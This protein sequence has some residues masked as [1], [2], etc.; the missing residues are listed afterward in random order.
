MTMSIEPNRINS[1]QTSNAE[2]DQ[3]RASYKK[4][5]KSTL[6]SMLG[7][8]GFWLLIAFIVVYTLFPFYWAIVSS[9]TP[10]NDL[11]VTPVRFWP[12]AIT[13]EHYETVFSDGGFMRALLN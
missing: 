12:Q 2:L 7:K 4:A 10:T 8:I 3:I 6:P 9:L 5:N 11:Y 1:I 13:F